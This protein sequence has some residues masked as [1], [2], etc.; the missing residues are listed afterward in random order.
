MRA[1]LGWGDPTSLSPRASPSTRLRA[2]GTARHG[3]QEHEHEQTDR[4][5]L[6]CRPIHTVKHLAIPDFPVR[7]Y[8]AR[9]P[10]CRARA[11]AS[12]P[13]EAREARRPLHPATPRR[14]RLPCLPL[15]PRHVPGSFC[16]GL[17]VVRLGLATQPVNRRLLLIEGH[18]QESHNH[19]DV[20]SLLCP[21]PAR[22]PSQ[23]RG[24]EEEGASRAR[25]GYS[26]RWAA[27][28]PVCLTDS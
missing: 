12:E 16:Q 18:P 2:Y 24:R 10:A 22:Q 5:Q 6:P 4:R 21:R 23:A 8:F 19:P 26:A 7:T 13:L 3:G 11:Q 1:E 27:P 14:P 20:S 17:F 9:L 15:R 28:G 25:R